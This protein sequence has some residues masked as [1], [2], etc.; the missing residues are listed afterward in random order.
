MLQKTELIYV[1]EKNRLDDAEHKVRNLVRQYEIQAIAVGDGTAG[2]ET[3]QFVKK[4]NL[5][6]PI[7]LVN[8]DGASINQPPK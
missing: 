6:L 2:I 4:L 7:F 8:E 3:E 1:H 5:G